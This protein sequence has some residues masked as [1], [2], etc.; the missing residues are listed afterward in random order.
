MRFALLTVPAVCLAL[1]PGSPQAAQRVDGLAWLSGCWE[2]AQGSLRG[3]EQWM[4]PAGGLMLGMA[5]TL[6]DGKLVEYEAVRIYEDGDTLVYAASP[7]GQAPAEFRAIEVSDGR[8][9]FENLGHDF[10][11][12][13]IYRRAG[14]DSVVARIEGMRDGSLRGVDF[15]MRR[16]RCPG[17]RTDD[18]R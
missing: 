15:P 16:A 17:G 14:A 10:P 4:R 2:R 5:R 12:R 3:E 9:V 8:I 7:S 1:F 6:R 13:V 18:G 11:Q